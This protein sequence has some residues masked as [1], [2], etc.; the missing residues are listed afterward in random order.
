ML[1]HLLFTV[2][3]WG[4]CPIGPLLNLKKW[5]S[6]EVRLLIQGH[7][8]SKQIGSQDVH[9][10]IPTLIPA[11]NC[12]AAVLPRFRP[13]SSLAQPVQGPPN[14][15]P[16]SRSTPIDTNTCAHTHKTPPL[17]LSSPIPMQ[18]FQN[19]DLI[20]SDPCLQMTTQKRTS[21]LLTLETCSVSPASCLLTSS[22]LAIPRHSIPLVK[23]TPWSPVMW[24]YSEAPRSP[25]F[26][27]SLKMHLFSHLHPDP[28]LPHPPDKPLGSDSESAQ[29]GFLKHLGWSF[30]DALSSTLFAYTKPA[31]TWISFSPL[32][33]S[34]PP[35][36]RGTHFIRF[37]F[38]YPSSIFLQQSIHKSCIY[39]I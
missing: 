33:P 23:N 29:N 18:S 25:W 6:R 39:Y 10:G 21:K 9:P 38:V 15:I 11:F 4:G 27:S 1:P 26:F 28:A 36:L 13:S 20:T 14:Y 19:T 31:L 24:N 2:T 3:L 35:A 34:S 16:T 30:L 22:V 37:S 17:I 12:C 7:T 32:Q 5:K 8:V